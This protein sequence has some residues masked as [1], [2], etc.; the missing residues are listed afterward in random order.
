M[1]FC[2]HLT[3]LNP[4]YGAFDLFVSSSHSEAFGLSLATAMACGKPVV[5]T[6]SGGPEEIIEDG[7]SGSLCPAGD[8]GTLARAILE[9]LADDEKRMSMGQAARKRI[10]EKF[11]LQRQVHS[12]EKVFGETLRLK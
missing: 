8:S 12:L 6:R 1:F 9:L 10:E 2:G 5:S 7:I 3:D 4:V 11:S